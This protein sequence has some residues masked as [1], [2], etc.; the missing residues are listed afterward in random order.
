LVEHANLANHITWQVAQ[1]GLHE[2]DT[3]LQRTSFAFDAAGWEIWTPFC[4]GAQLVLLPTTAQQDIYAIFQTAANYHITIL[5]LVPSLLTT[6]SKTEAWPNT[7][8]LRYLFLGGESLSRELVTRSQHLAQQGLINLYGPTEATIDAIA[9]RANTVITGPTALLGRPISN[10]RIYLLDAH[11]QPVPLGAVGEIHIGGAGVARGYLNRPE[12]TAERFLTDPFSAVPGAR[13]YK[14]GDLARYLPDGNLEFLG[15]NDQQVKIR[16]FRIEPGEIQARL[17]EHP[18]VH[19]AVV[20]AR[21]DTPGDKRL[22]A[23]IVSH[24]DVIVPDELA[25]VLRTHLAA[26]L[27]EY[28]VPAAYVRLDALPLTPNGKL[29]RK[30]LPAPEGDAYARRGYEPPQGEI[31][32]TLAILW[33]ELLGI[34]RVSRHDNFF[35]LGGHSLLA[36]QLVSRTSGRGFTLIVT[37]VFQNPV[38]HNLAQRIAGNPNRLDRTRAIQV[39]QAGAQAPIFFVPSGLGDYSYIFALTKELDTDS[40]VYALPWQASHE[41]QAQTLE[42]RA[43]RMVTMIQAVQPQGPY[44]LAGYSS[45]GILAYAIAQRLLSLNET[46]EFIGLID[47]SLPFEILVIPITAQ[48]MLFNM[49]EVN[50]VPKNPTDVAIL[51]SYA[52]N[53]SLVELIEEGQRLG[54]LPAELDAQTE[55]IATEQCC[56]FRNAIHSYEIPTLPLVIH[57]FHA[58]ENLR[59]QHGQ[60]QQLTGDTSAESGADIVERETST[61]GWE[62]VLPLSSI[63]LVSI[64][65]NHWTMITSPENRAI[66]GTRFSEALQVAQRSH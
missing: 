40:P 33:A 48:Q 13:M 54:I 63:R 60:R 26:R 1:F 15:R 64:P 61:L 29:D 43:A 66:L 42:A 22:V 49:I 47:V 21:E 17:T 12:L 57:Q 5:Q 45:G 50:V 10:T 28:M 38:L 8:A 30:A 25:A 20:I 65:G 44:R 18:A 59:E 56:H 52:D 62:R 9:W 23:Y 53:L 41:A 36:V 6:L 4:I 39:R 32:Q 14:T 34:E 31:E 46:I 11:G 24:D 37:D 35:E 19:E 51:R 7:H 27:P 55:A 2:L 16:G 58:A 3:F